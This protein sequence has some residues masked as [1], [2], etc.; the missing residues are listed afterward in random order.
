MNRTVM[1][2]LFSVLTA[3]ATAATTLRWP[4]RLLGDLSFAPLALAWLADVAGEVLRRLQRI[5]EKLAELAPPT[6]PAAS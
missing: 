3:L 1:L 6:K 5:E 2:T 4:L